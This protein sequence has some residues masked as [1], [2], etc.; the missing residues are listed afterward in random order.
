MPT[1]VAISVIEYYSGYCILFDYPSNVVKQLKIPDFW[2][3][4]LNIASY[5][6]ESRYPQYSKYLGRIVV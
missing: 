2:Q 4:K 6:T 3:L 5:L 1:E